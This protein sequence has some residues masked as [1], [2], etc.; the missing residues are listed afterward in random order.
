MTRSMLVALAFAGSVAAQNSY[1]QADADTEYISRGANTQGAGKV[2][3]QF[4]PAHLG[5]A[6]NLVAVRFQ[7]ANTETTM[8]SF[9]FAIHRQNSDGLPDW[10]GTPVFS[11]TL[12]AAVGYPR[13][14][15]TLPTPLPLNFGTF[16]LTW[17]L[18]PAPGWTTY[19]VSVYMHAGTTN[20]GLAF[21][22][23]NIGPW[24]QARPQ[25]PALPGVVEGLSWSDSPS[26]P[27]VNPTLDRIWK[28][29][30]LLDSPVLQSEA[31]NP[32]VFCVQNVYNRG[33]AAIDPDFADAGALSPS[34]FDD[35]AWVVTGG[36]P[37]ANGQAFLFFSSV[38]LDQPAIT[39][40][41]T[42]LLDPTDRLFTILQLRT[43][44]DGQGFGRVGPI[45]LGPGPNPL[46]TGLAAM[47]NLH[48]QALA[49]GPTLNVALTN[50]H[51]MRT[52]WPAATTYTTTAGTPHSFQRGAIAQKVRVQNNGH[53]PVVV[54]G[55]NQS[56]VLQ[57]TTVRERTTASVP[58]HPA[59]VT[60]E[61]RTVSTRNVTGLFLEQ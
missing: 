41:G 23:G 39:P 56:Q 12:T 35:P 16:Y 3:Q 53:G 26:G 20:A 31:Y 11:T 21:C 8:Q 36:T 54:V 18:P 17:D 52:P 38:V 44:L 51:T 2:G 59:T 28:H 49:V 34:R 55:L 14:T 46:R 32:A 61:I 19:G 4:T 15:V 5:G 6:Q 7:M 22:T 50:L 57:Q 13:Y 48:A 47:G 24:E 60:V 40:F 10:A 30:L 33:H 27:I 42:F 9:G 29:E 25:G 37:F 1:I 43:P 45:P 58:Y